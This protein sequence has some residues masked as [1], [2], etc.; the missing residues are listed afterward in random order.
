MA[1]S[2]VRLSPSAWRRS[3][4]AALT[5]ACWLLWVPLGLLAI[6]QA[7]VV[8]VHEVAVPRFVL[9]AFEGRLA[10]SGLRASFG[11]TWFDPTGRLLV[12]NVRLRLSGF[13]EPVAEA[14]SVFLRLDPWALLVGR[15]APVEERA[16]GLS[17]RVPAMLSPS[18][19]ADRIIRD[20]DFDLLP[21]RGKLE[22]RA[23]SGWMGPLALA[24]Y[25]AIRLPGSTPRT[26]G[27]LPGAPWFAANYPRWSRTIAAA[28]GKLNRLDR[29]VLEVRLTPAARGG[30]RAEFAFAADAVRAGPGL[31]LSARGVS[32]SG[33][34]V[35][36]R[37]SAEAADFEVRAA[38]ASLADGVRVD[39]LAAEVS[40]VRV[41]GSGRS[42]RVTA[43]GIRAAASRL[44]AEGTVA[45]DPAAVID[46]AAYPRVSGRVA[47]RLWDEP[48][49]ASG[50]A[51]L[52]RRTGSAQFDARAGRDFLEWLERKL[53]R[54]LRIAVGAR[55]VAL[56]GR[57]RF[58]P[59]WRFEEAEGRVEAR[60]V[61]YRGVNIGEARGEVAFAGG[62]LRAKRAYA[63]A[64]GNFARGDFEENVTSRDYRFILDGHIRPLD[65]APWIA[66]SWWKDFFGNF[67]VSREAI[68]ASVDLRGRWTDGRK[69]AVFVAFDAPEIAMRG[70]RFDDLRARLFAR[71]NFVDA[72][73]FTARIGSGTAT[74]VLTRR[75]DLAAHDW[76]SVDLSVDSTLDPATVGP[77]FGAEG[78]AWIHPFS[79]SRPPRV[80]LT[81]RFEGPAAPGG[82]HRT[83]SIRVRSPAPLTFH[84]IPLERAAFDV[85]IRDGNIELERVDAGVAG[86]DLKG[87]A[88]IS[89]AVRRLSVSA[90]LKGAG[91]GR[92]VV[93]LGRFLA[94][95]SA[96]APEPASR[97]FQGKGSARLDVA[98][99]ASG[100]L[101]GGY[102]FH[103]G[104]AASL[105]GGQIGQLR[106]LGLLSELLRFTALRFTAAH[107]DFRIDGPRL[108]FPDIAVTGANSAISAHG[109]YSLERGQ[110][111]FLAR[112]DPFE[113]SRALPQK[114]MD[115]LVTPLSG[116]LE[117]RLIGPIDKPEW[118]FANGPTNWLRNAAETA[119]SAPSSAGR[120][121]P[122]T[123]TPRS[124]PPAK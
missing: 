31:H 95:H 47:A 117:V 62:W 108:V 20:V 104:G 45:E 88:R 11:R 27:P 41:H 90:D 5:V 46:I 64:G 70:V 16:T 60:D 26:S 32:V 14:R 76:R 94:R 4:D 18:G 87:E 77:L 103:G 43:S 114:F 102:D 113:E 96:R 22:V 84:E 124:E 7:Y 112:L 85:K 98:M 25:G 39:S 13:N 40:G 37:A 59:G 10:A 79:F 107:A 119:P 81:G 51:A 91:L 72:L 33:K 35:L 21:E 2:P 111:D 9:D 17:L 106:M 118:V 50:R 53:G 24:G 65:I 28:L 12:E 58:G 1:S 34:W 49:A 97:Y 42:R 73:D 92:A 69:A 15:F 93:S 6:A 121:S 67:D 109:V 57:V 101:G 123:A 36:G 3:V 30:T 61:A 54:S 68:R 115:V 48:F 23:F 105:S 86:G 66:G 19:S 99:K 75:Y 55:P 89:G 100:R 56:S 8:H 63:R 116:V 74:G 122:D 52:D 71:P 120:P 82:E 29:P 80:A 44:A 38:A 78:H 110:L 83:V